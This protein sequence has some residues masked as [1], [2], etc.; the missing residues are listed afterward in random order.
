MNLI[1]LKYLTLSGGITEK[2][3]MHPVEEKGY[4]AHKTE[5]IPEYI[6]I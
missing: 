2:I 4:E 6:H 3:K 5:L 1:T